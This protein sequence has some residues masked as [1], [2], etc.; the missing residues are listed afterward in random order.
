M[1]VATSDGQRLSTQT[2]YSKRSPGTQLKYSYTYEDP[3]K[4]LLKFNYYVYVKCTKQ[5]TVTNTE[6]EASDNRQPP[7]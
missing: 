1:Q 6:F 5:C 3:F 2:Q 7:V 4:Y